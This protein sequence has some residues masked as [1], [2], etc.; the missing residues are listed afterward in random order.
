MMQKIAKKYGIKLILMFGSQVDKKIHKMSDIDIGVL[1]EKSKLDLDK[2]LFLLNDFQKLFPGKKIDLAIINDA[3]P[4]FLKKI[5]ENCRLLFGREKD[6]SKL[7][8]YSF[9][10]FCD[11]QKYFDLEKEFA[12]H[13]IQEFK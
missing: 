12:H 2:H 8:L 1:L 9:H 10:Q 3:D 5:L 13:F 11:Y 6:L 4:L 7:K